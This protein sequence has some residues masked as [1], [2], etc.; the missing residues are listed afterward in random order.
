[1]NPPFLGESKVFPYPPPFRQDDQ[2]RV[3][4]GTPQFPNFVVQNSPKSIFGHP[5]RDFP[6]ENAQHGMG[7]F[8]ALVE[9]R[10]RLGGNGLPFLAPKTHVM[11]DKG[12]EGLLAKLPGAPHGEAPCREFWG[13]SVP[14]STPLLFG[15][16]EKVE[17]TSNST[18]TEH[19][20]TPPENS[21]KKSIFHVSTGNEPK[22]EILDSNGHPK[23]GGVVFESNLPPLPD[24]PILPP[25][26]FSNP[27][28]DQVMLEVRKWSEFTV[29]DPISHDL[30]QIDV[31]GDLSEG[32]VM[33]GAKSG[34]TPFK[35][36]Q[37][38][39]NTPV[40]R[41]EPEKGGE[42]FPQNGHLM[43][44]SMG[45]VPVGVGKILSHDVSILGKLPQGNSQGI[46][47]QTGAEKL[48]RNISMGHPPG[49]VVSSAFCGVGK[50]FED[51]TPK[52]GV[53]GLKNCQSQG[54]AP[55]EDQVPQ[56][57]RFD[58][59]KGGGRRISCENDTWRREIPTNHPI[60]WSKGGC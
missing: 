21:A 42:K 57:L 7:T 50:R 23:K 33:W 26:D 18:L 36:T 56:G 29:E 55:Q 51:K 9:A 32:G 27:K 48:C 15:S 14:S 49:G 3:P 60:G 59:P 31:Q 13:H 19:L 47:D 41:F 43:E 11:D 46:L 58:P 10:T 45:R 6:R 24:L 28:L 35:T 54:F 30:R 37:N 2:D 20:A 34:F 53:F 4:R 40:C 12:D 39:Q 17:T 44:A 16:R 8:A 38:F 1:M 25:L 5:L 52:G 22:M